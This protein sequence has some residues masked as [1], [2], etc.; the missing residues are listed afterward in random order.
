MEL[1]V[2]IA[3]IGILISLLLPA[4]QS[5]REAA[6]TAQCSNK[7]KQIDLAVLTYESA[8]ETFPIDIPEDPC[9]ETNVVAT[10][11]GWMVRIL[12]YIEQQGLYDTMK[13]DG[14]GVLRARHRQRRSPDQ[15][16]HRHGRDRVLLP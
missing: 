14:S 6:R 11:V 3:I 10:G 7:L 13:I 16:G 2:V 8:W 12:P 9:G 4:V 15:G 5:A 1:L